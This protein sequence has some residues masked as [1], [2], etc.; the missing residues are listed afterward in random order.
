MSRVYVAPHGL[1]VSKKMNNFLFH[2]HR[3]IHFIYIFDNIKPRITKIKIKHPK[4]DI[5][6]FNAPAKKYQINPTIIPPIGVR[7]NAAIIPKII[8]NKI[9]PLLSST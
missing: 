6:F 5:I 1:L 7:V 4:N 2:I 9:D 8:E 3:G